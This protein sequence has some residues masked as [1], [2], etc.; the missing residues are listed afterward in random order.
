ML[1]QVM[2]LLHYPVM[3][4][5]NMLP[6][7]KW[8]LLGAQLPLKWYLQFRHRDMTRITVVPT[9]ALIIL[10]PELPSARKIPTNILKKHWAMVTF[11]L[12][13]SNLK[14]MLHDLPG[15]TPVYTTSLQAQFACTIT[16]HQHL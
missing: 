9:Q 2:R 11:I 13:A 4:P 1:A 16:S 8:H 10:L 6:T 7:M 3:L 15:Q 12:T 14:H 5:W